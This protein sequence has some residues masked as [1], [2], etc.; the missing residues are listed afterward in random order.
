MS[1]LCFIRYFL[2]DM[3][4]GRSGCRNKKLFAAVIGVSF[5]MPKLI[6]SS[7]QI[8]DCLLRAPAP[9]CGRFLVGMNLG[10]T[11]RVNKILIVVREVGLRA[12]RSLE[13]KAWF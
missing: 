6:S 8:A 10:G 7:M 5:K 1:F 13:R 12:F 11:G 4:H 9:C 3:S 2:L